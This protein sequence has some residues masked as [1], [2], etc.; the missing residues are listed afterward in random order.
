MPGANSNGGEERR[1]KGGR[2]S[3]DSEGAERIEGQY[4]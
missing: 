2:E 1:M 3:R 4:R